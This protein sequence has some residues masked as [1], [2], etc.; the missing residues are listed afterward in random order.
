MSLRF[1]FKAS[2]SRPELGVQASWHRINLFGISTRFNLPE[3]LKKFDR[4]GEG[5]FNPTRYKT[6]KFS[7]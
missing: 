4:V 2:V 1:S 6:A 3:K 7:C 5:G